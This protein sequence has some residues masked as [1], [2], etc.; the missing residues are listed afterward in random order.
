MLLFCCCWYSDSANSFLMCFNFRCFC[1]WIS[2][3]RQTASAP[4]PTPPPPP[5]LDTPLR[6]QKKKKRNVT[7][8]VLA[9]IE[10]W[11]RSWSRA[12]G[13]G[14]R[15]LVHWA[16]AGWESCALWSRGTLSRATLSLSRLSRATLELSKWRKDVPNLPFVEFCSSTINIRV[17]LSM[18]VCAW[19]CVS[20]G[21]VCR[22]VRAR[23]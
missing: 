21:C 11:S 17:C 8:G 18:C 7:V 1:I 10:G 19:V 14:R 5:T 12:G 16:G 4:S 9:G 13:R 3:H 22:V 6:L 15:Q 23:V 20:C 2:L